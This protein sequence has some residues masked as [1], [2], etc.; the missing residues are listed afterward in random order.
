MLVWAIYYVIMRSVLR[1]RKVR[2]LHSLM[3]W[4][5]A[6]APS[7]LTSLKPTVFAIMICV[8]RFSD[9]S[10]VHSFIASA[11]A[12]I[13]SEQRL[14][15]SIVHAIIECVLKFTDVSDL[16]FL[17]ISSSVTAFSSWPSD[18]INYDII[19]MHKNEVMWVTGMLVLL[20]PVLPLLLVSHSYRLSLVK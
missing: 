19:I 14:A 15:L 13:I 12:T 3:V 9:V 18:P 17:N 16:P 11:N 2:D 1:S 7:G 4:A 20:V 10:N 8:L 6:T 5:S